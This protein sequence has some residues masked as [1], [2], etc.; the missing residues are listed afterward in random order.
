MPNYAKFLRE[1]MSNKRNL[2]EFETIKLKEECSAIL[3]KKLLHKLKD[4]GSFNTPCNIV[5]KKLG[6]GEIKPTTL[7]LQLAHRSI[8][9]PKDIIEDVLVRLDKF[10]FLVDFVL[11]DMKEDEKVPLT[12]GQRFLAIGRVLIDMQEKKLTL[13]VDEE[14]VTF[15][16]HREKKALEKEKVDICKMIQSAEVIGGNR[17]K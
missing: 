7:T 2:E 6:L 17:E 8:T 11:L 12:L 5:F 4:S 14:Q 13:R 15:Y 1:V 3:Q 16:I 10:I 9:Y